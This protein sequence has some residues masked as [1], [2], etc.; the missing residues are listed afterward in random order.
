[1]DVILEFESKIKN[2]W[3]EKVYS[4]REIM[5][6]FGYDKWERFLW[7]INRAKVEIT[8]EKKREDNFFVTINKET[9]G[10]PKEDVLLTLGA[11]Y[12]VLKKC[13]QRKENVIILLEY[14]SSVLEETKN[15]QTVKIFFGWEKVFLLIILTFVF[16]TIVY[17]A[18]TYVEFLQKDS[19]GQYD[20]NILNT[21]ELEKERKR[22]EEVLKSYDAQISSVKVQTGVIISQDSPTEFTTQLDEYISK[23][24]DIL[25]NFDEN[26]NVRS[27]FLKIVM[28]EDLIKAYFSLWNHELFRDSCSLLSIGNCI[29]S[30]KWN[31]KAFW[32]FWEK[33]KDGYELLEVRKAKSGTEKN[34][35]CVVYKYKLKYDTSN[36]YITETFN[37]TTQVKNG[38]EQITG[39]FCEA[40]E[41]WWKNIKCPFKLQTY[42]CK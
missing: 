12:L 15:K 10:R 13:D 2:I 31:L 40:I 26:F 3:W 27:D 14:L 1:M 37:Y 23:G 36:N 20:F 21:Q 28:W 41:K 7:A 35:Y 8:D 19:V 29:S 17:Y 24:W 25:K 5:K 6:I 42:Y 9:G 16:S 33:T 38:F 32:N 4:A 18:Q 39:R 34:I 22:Q 30:T 11:C